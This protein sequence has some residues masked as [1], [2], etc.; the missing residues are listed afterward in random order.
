MK[1]FLKV[2]LFLLFILTL[3]SCSVQKAEIVLP[4]NQFD[5]FLS[6]NKDNEKYIFIGF[7]SEYDDSEKVFYE[8]KFLESLIKNNYSV[9]DRNDLKDILNE[10]KLQLTGIVNNENIKETGSLTGADILIKGNFSNFNG[11]K[12]LSIYFI[13]IKTSRIKSFHNFTFESNNIIKVNDKNNI[14][15]EAKTN[16]KEK[17]YKYKTF[18]MK[19]F[20]EDNSF[21]SFQKVM[22]T[23]QKLLISKYGKSVYL[24]PE[25][26]N[27]FIDVKINYNENIELKDL[28]NTVKILEIKPKISFAIGKM[29]NGKPQYRANFKIQNKIIK[30][31]F[32]LI[33]KINIEKD[34]N[35]NKN[36]VL[37]TFNKFGENIVSKLTSKN[38]G[39][40]FFIL[41]NNKIISKIR[42]I[43]PVKRTARI[44]NLN[45]EK[46]LILRF[47]YQLNDLKIK[48]VIYN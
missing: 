12:M 3:V 37:I 35:T 18:N 2:F 4:E 29:I 20:L 9:L 17:K 48:K 21:E 26:K 15:N 36:F 10:H 22:R 6:S 46:E 19:V 32:R 5:E 23:F 44:N 41:L 47:L 38:I 16:N 14:Q 1:I 30:L 7:D 25:Y 45:E 42:I 11:K 31:D 34:K 40:Y 39:N 8:N 28:K 24:K 43:E 27:T 13:D 33:D